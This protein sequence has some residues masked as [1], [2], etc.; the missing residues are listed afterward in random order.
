[1]N[2]SNTPPVCSKEDFVKKAQK[3]H[4]IAKLKGNAGTIGIQDYL[5]M[6][7]TVFSAFSIWYKRPLFHARGIMLSHWA[8]YSKNNEVK[9]VPM[10]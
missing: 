3:L 2:E 8:E 9:F 6:V 10:G 4:D 1:M 7:M 5:T